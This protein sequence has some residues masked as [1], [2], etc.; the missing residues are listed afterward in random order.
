MERAG[1]QGGA[2]QG[3]LGDRGRPVGQGECHLEDIDELGGCGGEDGDDVGGCGG[4]DQ[5]M[6]GLLKDRVTLERAVEA[7]GGKLHNWGGWRN[8][9]QGKRNAPTSGRYLS[10][11]F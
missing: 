2:Q 1:D 10:R 8:W 9:P 4:E 6:V 3:K 5:V 11:R 7:G